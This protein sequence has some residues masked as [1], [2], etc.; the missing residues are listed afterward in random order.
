M[1]TVI[2]D[3]PLIINPN[4][5]NEKLFYKWSDGDMNLDNQNFYFD[6]SGTQIANYYKTKQIAS[7]P[8]VI[9]NMSQTNS[10]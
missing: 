5:S 6:R 9:N 3:L 10:L 2:S 1:S 8:V 4:Q 7:T